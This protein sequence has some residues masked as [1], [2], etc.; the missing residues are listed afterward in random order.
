MGCWDVA[1]FGFDLLPY[2]KGRNVRVFGLLLVA[3]SW[4]R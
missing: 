3:V 4:M 2:L 1:V